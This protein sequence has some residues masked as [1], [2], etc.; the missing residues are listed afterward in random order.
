MRRTVGVRENMSDR[1]DRK[2][3]KLSGHVERMSEQL[4]TKSAQGE[5]L[6]KS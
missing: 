1:L 3:L 6:S 5:F 2:V 4:S